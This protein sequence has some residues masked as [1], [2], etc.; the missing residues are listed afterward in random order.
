[1]GALL[2]TLVERAKSL[3]DRDSRARTIAGFALLVATFVPLNLAMYYWTGVSTLK[4]L[5]LW[6]MVNDLAFDDSWL[7]M[8]TAL[9]WIRTGPDGSLYDEVFFGRHVKFQYAPTSLLPLAGLD[10]VG[11]GSDAV[12]LNRISRL[13]LLLS[14]VGTGTLTRILLKH[15]SNGEQNDSL[16]PD[17]AAL[18]VGGAAFLFYPLTHGYAI[19]Q[20]Q[21]WINALFV[22]AFLAWALDRRGLAGGMVGLICLLKPQYAIFVLWGLLR[23]EWRF[24]AVLVTTGAAGLTASILLFGLRNNI[25]YLKVLSYISRH[26]EAILANQS[27][28]GLLHRM[29]GNDD[30]LVWNMTGF[31]AFHPTV[32]VLTAL[33]SI[34]ILLI[35]L[36][37]GRRLSGVGDL[38]QFQLAALAFT[39]ASPLAWEPNYGVLAPVFATLFCFVLAMPCGQTRRAWLLGLAA[40]FTL[41][42]NPFGF[43]RFFAH[44]P[45]LVLQSYLLFAGLGVMAMLWR[46]TKMRGPV[47]ASQRMAPTQR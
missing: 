40:T 4:P 9:K 12:V 11:L 6:L 3:W 26:G 2:H 35:G 14:A 47:V 24:A 13:L 10:A 27:F 25:E 17:L 29:V 19:G 18:V 34:L 36:W 43:V 44:T 39:I 33:S 31:P 7:P 38:L 32:F 21:V 23:R 41:S 5:Q 42:A 8:R 28:N 15:S 1:M 46:A 20:A 30:G 22:F 16:T 45:L 37:P